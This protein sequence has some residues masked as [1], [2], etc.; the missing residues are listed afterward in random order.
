M[1]RR[2]NER[3]C[4][5]PAVPPGWVVPAQQR[6]ASDRIEA[7]SNQRRAARGLFHGLITLIA[8]L[9]LLADTQGAYTIALLSQ[10]ADQR[11]VEVGE[12]FDLDV[13][14]SSESGRHDA[15]TLRLLF[16]TP[17]LV[18]KSMSWSPPYLTSGRDDASIPPALELP[19]AILDDTIT[20]AGLPER[21]ADIY[22]SNALPPSEA[23]SNG[24]LVR[25]ALSVPEDYLG[26]EDV[27]IRAEPESFSAGFDNL[28]IAAT[29][30][31][32]LKI[33]S[34]PQPAL[35]LLTIERKEDEVLLSWRDIARDLEVEYSPHLN[36]GGD[37]RPLFPP[38]ELIDGHFKV[39]VAFR[40][41]PA[42][43]FYRLRRR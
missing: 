37:W 38:P 25:L 40:E 19:A 4:Q 13:V 7:K 33:V 24:T 31:F 16:S 5:M 27:V 21:Q 11:T 6:V 17:G 1:I 43:G 14:L 22:L 29:A 42:S 30:P 12:S 23:F 34:P 41:P 2:I 36:D 15:A 28:R 35:P 32:R 8:Y 3:I 18:L 20:G 10:N 26:F 9:L 39:T